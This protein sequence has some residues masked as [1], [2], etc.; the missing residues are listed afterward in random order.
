MQLLAPVFSLYLAAS[1]SSCSI[2]LSSKPVTYEP[3]LSP[4]LLPPKHGR[5]DSIGLK[6]ITLYRAKQRVAH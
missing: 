6:E 2:L 3:Q 4:E 5:K 1:F